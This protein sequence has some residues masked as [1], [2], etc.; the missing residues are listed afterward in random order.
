MKKFINIPFLITPL[1][2]FISCC[3]KKKMGGKEDQNLIIT[4]EL[5]QAVFHCINLQSTNLFDIKVIDYDNNA[6]RIFNLHS[7]N[8]NG[9]I[10]GI[11]KGQT[12]QNF[13]QAYLLN[14]RE[15]NISLLSGEIFVENSK[16]SHLREDFEK[17]LLSYFSKSLV[18]IRQLVL[19]V[20]VLLVRNLGQNIINS[21]VL[22]PHDFQHPNIQNFSTDNKNFN[23]TASG[24]TP[25][26]YSDRLE[27]HNLT[28]L[29]NKLAAKN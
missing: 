10:I 5:K 28:I 12:R 11:L 7:S 1:A 17:L 20:H 21:K 18:D 25:T 2:S 16:L 14:D 26:N 4:Q 13:P 15:Y 3:L 23:A 19:N 8:K 24:I 22:V 27:N 6:V 29:I 9:E